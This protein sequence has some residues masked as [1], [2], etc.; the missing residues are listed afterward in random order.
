MWPS[1]MVTA[2]HSLLLERPSVSI[3][4]A[5]HVV[6]VRRMTLCCLSLALRKKTTGS[7]VISGLFF[8]RHF[9]CFGGQMD[10]YCLFAF[11]FFLEERAS[12]QTR[13]PVL[14]SDVHTPGGL[15]CCKCEP[16]EGFPSFP[17]G[18]GTGSLVITSSVPL[19][20]PLCVHTLWTAGSLTPQPSD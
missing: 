14:V 4:A 8:M 20:C 1:V 18:S 17:S 10:I 9:M 15:A 12:T 5:A 7:A 13:R 11:C 16:C 19:A 2:A 6:L 3:V